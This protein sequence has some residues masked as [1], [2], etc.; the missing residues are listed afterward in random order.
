MKATRVT[1]W[2]ALTALLLGVAPRTAHAQSCGVMSD[3]ADDLYNNYATIF[4]SEFP[5]DE[6]RCVKLEKAAVGACHKAVA[7]MATCQ[8]NELKGAL[9]I[10]KQACDTPTCLAFWRDTLLAELEDVG[11]AQATAEGLCDT[12]A[13]A[14]LGAACRGI[15]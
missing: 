9:R 6:Q 10:A 15:P 4:G 1:L 13:E 2:F 8:E 7:A 14:I 5:L 3:E 12:L 11:Y